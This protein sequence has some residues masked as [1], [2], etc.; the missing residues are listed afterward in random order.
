MADDVIRM[1]QEAA[2]RV[3]HMREQAR[4]MV[5]NN[6]PPLYGPNARREEG[7]APQAPEPARRTP[8]KPERSAPSHRPPPEPPARDAGGC[9][10]PKSALASLIGEH[11]Q[12]FLL[13]LAVLLV[14]NDARI[15]LVIALLYLAM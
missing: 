11:D 10:E 3:Q 9:E 1:Q 4:R 8:D 6:P 2:A 13:M 7:K 5:S 12:L 14:K 15:E